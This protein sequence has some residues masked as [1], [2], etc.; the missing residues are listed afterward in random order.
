[1]EALHAGDVGMV[2][3]KPVDTIEHSPP[4]Y[5][6]FRDG[7]MDRAIW[8]CVVNNDEYRL[9]G[10]QFTPDDIVMDV[11]A[12]IGCFVWLAAKHGCQNVYRFEP[13]SDSFQLLK[14][15]T[16]GIGGALLN[17]AVWMENEILPWQPS[18]NPKNTGGGDVF[19]DPGK[20]GVPAISF[21]RFLA[22][23]GPIRFLKLDCEGAEFPILLTSQQLDRI[24]QIALEYH[25]RGPGTFYEHP[26]PEWAAIPGVPVWTG[27]VLAEHLEQAGF[28]VEMVPGDEHMG[29]IFA[30]R[31]D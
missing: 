5:W 16:Q 8:D 28:V 7:T 2:K 22:N 25:E 14:H 26:I 3:L 1:M 12:H 11:G 13:D 29:K 17:H 27:E 10:I 30:K 24:Q 4:P 15:N 9:S 20:A 21:D 18:D 31:K 19:T 6:K 23:T